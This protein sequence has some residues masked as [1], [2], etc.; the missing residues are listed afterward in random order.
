MTERLQKILA[1]AG[2]GSRRQIESWI[3]KGRI[4]INGRA[5]ILGDKVNAQ[6]RI[7]LDGRDVQI[8]LQASHRILIYYKP[9][10]ELVTRKDP[11]GRPS[12]FDRLPE[13]EGGRWVGIGRLDINTSG[14]L[15][16]TT[17]GELANRLM[18][19]SHEVEREYAA[20]IFGEIDALILERL[21]K[22]VKLEDG[23]SRFESIR[24]AGGKG[25]NCWY[26]VVL[27]RGRNRE[28]RRLW[29]SQ[30]LTVSRLI[31][32]RYGSI[33]LPPGLPAGEWLELDPR[34]KDNLYK[35]VGLMPD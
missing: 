13:V 31:R 10:G 12:V 32:I 25:A 30:G 5:A 11:E 27:K 35:S 15:L 34:Q 19:P 3:E 18:H 14:L 21:L 24:D 9:E 22:G 17:D 23:M 7:Q 4:T 33:R 29:E 1:R 20:R 8:Q 28:V 16:V 2:Y 6:D 26:H